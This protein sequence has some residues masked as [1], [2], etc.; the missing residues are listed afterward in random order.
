MAGSAK[1]APVAKTAAAVSTVE[2]KFNSMRLLP[3]KV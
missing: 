3:K 1:A 2:R